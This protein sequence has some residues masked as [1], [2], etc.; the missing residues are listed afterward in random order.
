[1]SYNL[2]IQE[3]R[4]VEVRTRYAKHAVE[5]RQWKWMMYERMNEKKNCTDD[6]QTDR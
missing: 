6:R 5:M 3:D 2:P 1:M 4:I